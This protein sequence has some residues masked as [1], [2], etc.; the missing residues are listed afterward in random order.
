LL[1]DQEGS[2]PDAEQITEGRQSLDR[3]VAL[4]GRGLYMT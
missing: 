2:M 3:A 1:A 4:L